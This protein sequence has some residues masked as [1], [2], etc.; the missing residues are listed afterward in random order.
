MKPPSRPQI[1]ASDL[2]GVLIHLA[3]ELGAL[4]AL[5]GLSTVL[6]WALLQL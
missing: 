3:S 2:W 4:A 1:A 6:A 5:V